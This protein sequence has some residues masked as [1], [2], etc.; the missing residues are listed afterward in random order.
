MGHFKH[1]YRKQLSAD[2]L[3]RQARIYHRSKLL[4]AVAALGRLLGVVDRPGAIEFKAAILN[5]RH[6]FAEAEPYL[7][8]TGDEVR[9]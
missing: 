5:A 3:S 1:A 8:D 2:G 7:H 9:R 4:K 6:A